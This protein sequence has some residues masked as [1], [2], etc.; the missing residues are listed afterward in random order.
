GGRRVPRVRGE[1][2][3]ERPYMGWARS[4]YFRQELERLDEGLRKE[5]MAVHVRRDHV[6][7]DS[8]RELHRK[9]PE[10]MKNR[11]YI[12]FEGEEGQDA[13][14][15]LREWY[16]IISRE[17]FNPMYALFRTSPGDRV[18][19]TIN[20]SSHCNPNHLSYFKFVGRIV[21]K[22]VYDNRL[23]E[24]YF[25]RSF[26]KH[27]L[28]KSVRCT[29]GLRDGLSWGRLDGA[30]L[31]GNGAPP[32]P[33]PPLTP[34]VQEFGVCEVRDL[35][36][37]GA[38]ILVTEENKKEYVHLVCQMRMTGRRLRGGSAAF[39]EGFY[40]IIPKRL[41]SIFTEQELE[42]LISGLPTIDIDD[43]K[44]NT[45]YHKYQ[46]NSIQ[47]RGRPRADR[48][49][50]LQFVTGTSKVPLQGFAALE[51]MNGI[52]KFQIHR[53]DRSTDRLAWGPSPPAGAGR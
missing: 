20:P 32:H 22:A 11:L 19:Y 14:G 12:V 25:T 4:V 35:K 27:I 34:Q 44:S 46:S 17:M 43:L 7:E 42:L 38:N 23:L 48:A 6:F 24:C 50:F 41:I 49:K 37:N 9:S 13:G 33:L 15:L 51:G 1:T 3:G 29:G 31:S 30:A 53:D 28:G 39:L 16:M 2:D 36:P 8:Y 10:E 40:E 5:D 21:A 26:Y 52:Q 47:V 45:E 18:T